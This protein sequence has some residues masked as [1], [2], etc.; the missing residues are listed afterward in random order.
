MGVSKLPPSLVSDRHP[1]S[2]PI[3]R[4]FNLR[5]RSFISYLISFIVPSQLA[6]IRSALPDSKCSAQFAINC[7]LS[8]RFQLTTAL[9][10][11]LLLTVDTL[12]SCFQ[13][14]LYR[15]RHCTTIGSSYCIP[16]LDAAAVHVIVQLLPSIQRSWT[17]VSADMSE[18][19]S[20]NSK[21]AVLDRSI[22]GNYAFYNIF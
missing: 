4:L 6:F 13:L 8:S 3:R 22:L 2:L 7:N 5:I 20:W 10:S 1:F 15:I 16:Q 9:S 17:I 21:Q 18:S 11:H 14:S 19:F 12:S